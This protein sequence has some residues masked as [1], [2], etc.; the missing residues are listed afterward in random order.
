LYDANN[1]AYN[2]RE[3]GTLQDGTGGIF[4]GDFGSHRG[5]SLLEIVAASTPTQFVGQ[6][7]G[8]V[9]QGGREISISQ[10][11]LAGLNVTRRVFVPRDGYFARYL[12][13]LNNPTAST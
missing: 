6:V 10:S 9:G 5:A 13:V 3:N 11:G 12:E 4:G 1:L 2:L 7:L 8:T